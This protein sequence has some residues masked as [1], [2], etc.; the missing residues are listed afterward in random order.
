MMQIRLPHR[1]LMN[2]ENTALLKIKIIYFV[3]ALP[4]Q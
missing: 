3:E 4:D 2:P 1:K